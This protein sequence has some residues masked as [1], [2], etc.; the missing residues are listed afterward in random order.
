MTATSPPGQRPSRRPISLQNGGSSSSAR[1]NSPSR[2]SSRCHPVLR[3]LPVLPVGG[4]NTRWVMTPNRPAGV[5]G[6]VQ[7]D[8]TSTPGRTDHGFLIGHRVSLC[9]PVRPANAQ[10]QVSAGVGRRTCGRLTV[11]LCDVI[12]PSA[13][14]A[15]L[16]CASRNVGFFCF[17]ICYFLGRR[18]GD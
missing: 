1:P 17:F 13:A 9:D 11:Q 5:K 16:A 7:A 18:G 10:P 8:E 4:E 12:R 15:P 2:C 14:F 6:L 3:V